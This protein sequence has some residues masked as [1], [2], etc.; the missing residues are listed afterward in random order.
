[1]ERFIVVLKVKLFLSYWNKCFPDVL[2]LPKQKMSTGSLVYFTFTFKLN[3]KRTL[4]LLNPA[5]WKFG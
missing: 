4:H 2:D 1:M 3:A 5:E